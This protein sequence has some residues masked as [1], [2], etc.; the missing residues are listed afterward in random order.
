MIDLFVSIATLPSRPTVAGQL[1]QGD[2]MGLAKPRYELNFERR[3]TRNLRWENFDERFVFA[4]R[5]ADG[6]DLSPLIKGA[7]RRPSQPRLRRT[8]RFLKDAL[9]LGGARRR[10]P[11]NFR[12]PATHVSL[13]LMSPILCGSTLCGSDSRITRSASLPFSSEPMRSPMPICRAASMVTA[14]S[15]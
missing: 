7:P 12:S 8:A 9:G 2:F 13:T 3:F 4:R 6:A 15:A 14:R 5:G 10:Q 11:P 1:A